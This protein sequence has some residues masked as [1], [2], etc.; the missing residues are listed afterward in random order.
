MNIV[1]LGI[2]I[3]NVCEFQFDGNSA[4]NLLWRFE[5]ELFEFFHVDDLIVL[6]TLFKFFGFHLCTHEIYASLFLRT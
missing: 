6:P 2:S 3:K 5:F 1:I 4:G